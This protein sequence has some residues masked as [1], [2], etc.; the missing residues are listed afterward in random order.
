LYDIAFQKDCPKR[1]AI[2]VARLV[3]FVLFSSLAFHT[4]AWMTINE[5]VDHSIIVGCWYNNKFKQR[6]SLHANQTLSYLQG[7]VP[8]SN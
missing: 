1:D 4:T 2:L 7:R 5:N 8:G 6:R 3:E